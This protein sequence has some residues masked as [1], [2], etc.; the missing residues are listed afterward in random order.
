VAMFRLISVA[1]ALLL[2][3]SACSAERSSSTQETA[4]T[5]ETTSTTTTSTTVAPA[6]TAAPA[7][8]TTSTTAAPVPVG[9]PA[10][11]SPPPAAPAP[12]LLPGFTGHG[13]VTIASGG[14][15]LHVAPGDAPF[16][17]AREGL[18]FAAHRMDGEWIEV[19]TSCDIPA[20][21]HSSQVLAQ[22]PAPDETI[23]A[24]FDLD[25]A[26]I[27]I[28]P[29]HGG[30]W[31][32]GAVSPSGLVEKEINLDISRRVVDLLSTSHVVDWETGDV[33]HGDEIPAAGWVILTRVGDE[34]TGDYEAGLIFRSDLANSA[35][36]HAMV[37]IHNNAGWELRLPLPGSD[38][39]YQ[40]QIPESRRFARIMVQE[41]HRSFTSF[42]AD[43][44]GG[45]QTGAK[46]RLSPRDGTSQYYGIL[47]RS[48]MPTVIA[49]GA[50]IANQSEADLLETADFRQAYAEA[51]YRAL[52]R[53]LTTD[54]TGDAVD[55]D[56]EVWAG[57]AGSGDA[58]PD[59]VIPAQED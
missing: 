30:P 57:S 38:V 11:P 48:E 3:A 50:Y 15:G 16:V 45:I 42:E 8:T 37:A 47:R 10:R 13:V 46:S 22:P 27:V 18:V 17:L 41:M 9:V 39:Y 52:V 6:T 4:A 59:C 14:A 51:V 43:W 31:N 53:F 12:A 35:N 33:Y 5:A 32:T 25:Q 58:R 24:G 54:D 29:G 36:A 19:F 21:V 55:T 20:W 44:V 26:T 1:V 23:G 28:D 49:E 56:P 7:T 34:D 2:L 40:S